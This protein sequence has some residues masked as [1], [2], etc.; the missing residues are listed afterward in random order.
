M[1][2]LILSSLLLGFGTGST[3]PELSQEG[4]A[5]SVEVVDEAEALIKSH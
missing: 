5:S 3:V 4:N 1:N 2:S